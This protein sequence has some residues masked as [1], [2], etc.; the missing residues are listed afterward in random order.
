M[1]S[2]INNR[3][4]YK[5]YMLKEQSFKKKSRNKMVKINGICGRQVTSYI[6]INQEK[7]RI[8]QIKHKCGKY[9][10]LHLNT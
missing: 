4:Q 10:H 1:S 9:T 8:S 5:N 2:A 3:C 6:D 7:K